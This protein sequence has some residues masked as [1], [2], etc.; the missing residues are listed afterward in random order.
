M[1]ITEVRNGTPAARASLRAGDIIVQLDRYKIASM[2]DYSVLLQH[3]PRQ[4]GSR[5]ASCVRS[6]AVIR[7]P[8]GDRVMM[9]SAM[10]IVL[11]PDKFKGSLTA[12]QV[13]EAMRRGIARVDPSIQVECDTDVGR[14]RRIRFCAGQHD[15]GQFITRRVTGP[16]P[17]MKVDA[18]FGILG[19]SNVQTA[20]IEMSSASGFERLRPDQRDPLGTTTFGTG[21]LI[22]IAIEEF[23]AKKI[24]LGIGGSATIDAG[25]GAAR[26]ADFQSSSKTANRFNNRTPVRPATLSASF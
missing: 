1:L 20:V 22:K 19:S 11:A 14:W 2:D 15:G 17:E 5:S 26:R 23:S 9:R 25:I 10:R 24:L 13:C 12:A 16:L 18:V 6:M 21:E 8:S 7:S 4:V 3:L